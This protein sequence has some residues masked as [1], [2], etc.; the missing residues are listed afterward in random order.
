[1]TYTSGLWFQWA[2]I[3]IDRGAGAWEARAKAEAGTKQ[4]EQSSQPERL[5]GMVSVTA[6]AAAVDSF[7]GSIRAAGALPKSRSKPTRRAN[8]HALLVKGRKEASC[9]VPRP[10]PSPGGKPSGPDLTYCL[11]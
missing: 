11:A 4:A 9:Q 6:A 10:Q 3:A 8:V 7:S 1:M 5:D 2:W